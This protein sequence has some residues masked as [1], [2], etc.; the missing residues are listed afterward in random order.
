MGI[1]RRQALL[2]ISALSTA[3]L[4]AGCSRSQVRAQPVARGAVV[5]ALGDSLTHG[6]GAPPEAAYPAVLE[7]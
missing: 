7:G 6:T 2:T 3:V 5:L 4:E 1:G